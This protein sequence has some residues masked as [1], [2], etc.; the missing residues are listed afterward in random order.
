MT[1]YMQEKI[2]KGGLI[3]QEIEQLRQTIKDQAAE[4][5][6]LKTKLQPYF[7][8]DD[9]G[10]HYA[11]AVDYIETIDGDHLDNKPF[12]FDLRGGVE[13]GPVW[14]VASINER[15]YWQTE[16]YQTEEDAKSALDE[17]GKTGVDG[18]V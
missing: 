5:G 15:E 14:F 17:L 18:S 3:Q 10:D 12:V 1:D 9:C 16:Q 4:I 8:W 7:F 6:R 2:N 13:V 11:E